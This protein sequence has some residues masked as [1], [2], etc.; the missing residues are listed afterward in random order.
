MKV[1]IVEGHWDYEGF[2]IEGVHATREGAEKRLKEIE[3]GKKFFDSV[4]IT[5][6]EVKE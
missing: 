4:E 5:E 6:H 1:Y 3:E 2:T